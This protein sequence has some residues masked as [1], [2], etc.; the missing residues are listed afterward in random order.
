MKRII[1]Q[2]LGMFARLILSKNQIQS[3][4]RNYF[5]INDWAAIR[6]IRR[7][8]SPK[9][10]EIRTSLIS[11]RESLLQDVSGKISSFLNHQKATGKDF[12]YFYSKYSTKP[13]LYSSAYACMT[14]SLLDKLN[15][16]S[17]SQRSRWIAHFDKY[18]NNDDGLFYDPVVDS[19]LFR[20]EDWW[21]ARH[22]ALHM[23]IA[24]T[25]L[26][27][28]PRYPFRFLEEYYDHER[29]KNWLDGFNWSNSGMDADDIDNK[30][31]NIGCL[32]QYQRD[33]WKDA[34]A[35]SAVAY[36]QNYLSDKINPETGIWGRFDVQDP[37]QRSRMVQFAYHLF[38]LFFYDNIPMKHPHQVVQIVLATQNDLGGFGVKLNS[39]ACEDIDSI[40]ILTKL[41]PLVPT[42]REEIRS[43]L[44]KSLCWVLCNQVKDGG[45]VFRWDESLIY[46]HEE[47]AHPKN[48][49]GMFPTWFR[50]LSL[51]Y[52]A[53]YFSMGRFRI[54]SVPGLE[55]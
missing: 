13:T 29:I 25:D 16:M 8:V 1:R 30:I 42:Y 3:I 9:L 14:L 18:Q 49:G 27:G 51:A 37:D 31:M 10:S 52:L 39:S 26:G 55:N 11:D 2:S 45:F 23:I 38:P 7:Q 19:M 24:Y 54:R 32:L 46:G 47:M 17:P 4:K 5:L 22:L 40:Y 53:R 6:T 43:S 21:G 12:D 15:T 41:S 48:Q 33:T 36:I 20:T 34:Q 35:G 44:I 50:T 28:K